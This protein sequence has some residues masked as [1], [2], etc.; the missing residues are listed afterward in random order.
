[1]RTIDCEFSAALLT[2]WKAQLK[3]SQIYY[4]STKYSMEL[5]IIIYEVI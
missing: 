3:F 2:T 1:M 4:I 5:L